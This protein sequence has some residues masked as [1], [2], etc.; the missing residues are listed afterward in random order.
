MKKQCKRKIYKLINP[1]MHALQGVAFLQNSELQDL[2]LR[3]LSAIRAFVDGVATIQDWQDV[4]ALHSLCEIMAV[5]NCGREALP[6]ADSVQEIL[7]RLAQSYEN[8]TGMGITT[9][10]SA[11]FYDM[12]EFHDLQR[13]SVS[14]SEYE[15]YIESVANHKQSR[16]SLV[17]EIV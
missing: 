17:K 13:T 6:V 3:E 4:A 1:V 9:D 14:R 10:E 8:G 12:Y 5:K 2:R 16:S 7:T 15:N 11:L